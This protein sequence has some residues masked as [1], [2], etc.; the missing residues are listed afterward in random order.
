MDK[1]PMLVLNRALFRMIERTWDEHEHMLGR[2]TYYAN[3]FLSE[4]LSISRFA[5]QN[6]RQMQNDFVNTFTRLFQHTPDDDEEEPETELQARIRAPRAPRDTRSCS[7]CSQQQTA[8]AA[9]PSA[10]EVTLSFVAYC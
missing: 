10:E 3:G 7:S 4:N 1:L 5:F 9:A 8:A 6:L 2:C